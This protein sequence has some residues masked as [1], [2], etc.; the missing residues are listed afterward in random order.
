MISLY[1]DHPVYPGQ[2]RKFLIYLYV[3][4]GAPII[5][6]RGIGAFFGFGPKGG[7]LLIECSVNGRVKADACHNG[8]ILFSV[9]TETLLSPTL[10]VAT[11]LDRKKQAHSKQPRSRADGV[12]VGNLL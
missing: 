8:V 9:E 7:G 3:L 11:Q 2:K 10:R 12:S 1:P 4:V 5:L 6:Q